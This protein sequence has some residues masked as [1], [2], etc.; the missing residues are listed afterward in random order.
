[1]SK[2]DVDFVMT[3]D[4][5]NA[6]AA[7][8]AYERKARETSDR[9]KSHFSSMGEGIGGALEGIKDKLEGL[10]RITGIAFAYEA[11]E[12]LGGAIERLG[13][14]STKIRSMSQ[15]LGVTG[16]Q[17]Q[18]MGL[19]ASEAGVSEEQLFHGAER[20]A[21]LLLD[22][23]N[24]SG[25][26]IAA[27]HLLGIENDQLKDK[28]FGTAEALALLAQRLNDPKTA[29]ETLGALT[30]ELGLRGA[31]TASAIKALSGNL[32]E[33]ARRVRDV[34]GLN[35]E[36]TKKLSEAED[37]WHRLGIWI[38]NTSGKM[39]VAIERAQELSRAGGTADKAAPLPAGPT[40]QQRIGG[41]IERPQAAQANE[42]AITADLLRE[43]EF[44]YRA[45][46][47]GTEKRV[48]LAREFEAASRKFYGSANVLEVQQAHLAVIESDRAYQQERLRL[49]E[50]HARDVQALASSKLAHIHTVNAD[51]IQ[52][53]DELIAVET[54]HDEARDEMAR[55][56]LETYRQIQQ[57]KVAAGILTEQ[58]A[59]RGERDFENRAYA[60]QVA[61]LQ[62]RLKLVQDDMVQRAKIRDQIEVAAA[63]HEATMSLIAA[64]S[65]KDLLRPFKEVMNDLGRTWE[66][67]I[68]RMLGGQMNLRDGMRGAMASIGDAADMMVAKTI[69][70]LGKGLMMQA[71]FHKKG[72]LGDAYKAA[73]GAYQAMVG[74]PYV[75]PFIAPVAAAAAFTATA[76]FGNSIPSARAGFSVPAGVNPLT[77]LHE[78]E[79]VLPKEEAAAVRRM[80]GRG[81]GGQAP[82]IHIHATDAKSFERQLMDRNSG[83]AKALHRYF[84]DGGPVPA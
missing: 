12:K 47:E 84:R 51:S 26:A 68:A 16:T 46:K 9:A 24:N 63:K 78:Q 25:P 75:G 79:M 14:R 22:A 31:L 13:Q 45:E 1:M 55:I 28:T 34:N 42:H 11:I 70:A 7:L 36:Q 81:G 50:K 35:D 2:G 40:T 61:E 29:E 69:V 15:V 21:Q 18:A 77:Q 74:I 48:Q 58:E 53:L 76:A 37:A 72:V 73:S 20:V 39:L 82:Q 6:N 54:S 57:Q 71:I 43:L 66:G 10:G 32:E 67:G 5:S 80:A 19:A 4:A 8:E 60:I 49:E 59:L 41:A 62:R 17:F 3:G 65:Q 30:K 38:E 23:R 44:R 64:K 33:W 27:L 52:M 56:S 83:V